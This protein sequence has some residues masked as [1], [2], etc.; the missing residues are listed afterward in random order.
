MDEQDRVA[1]FLDDHDL[2]APPAYRLLDLQSEVGELAKNVN[3]ST[4]YG[5]TPADAAVE[6]D[7]LGDALFCLLALADETGTDAGDALE[8][9]L[10]KYETRLAKSG[11][12]GSGE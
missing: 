11:S 1:A 8:T 12:A 10:E 3:E 5:S 2:H 9:A 7:E 6:A 4:D